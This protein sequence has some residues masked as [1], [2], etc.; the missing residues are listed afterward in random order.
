[1]QW[2]YDHMGDPQS[3][4]ESICGIRKLM[5]QQQERHAA[6]AQETQKRLAEARAQHGLTNMPAFSSPDVVLRRRNFTDGRFVDQVRQLSL[7]LVA[8]GH[9]PEA[10]KIRDQALTVLDDARLKSAVA[11]AVQKTANVRS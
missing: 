6:M 10:E 5:L 2:C 7:V 4:Y 8:I 9:Q 11:D 3:K 1:Y